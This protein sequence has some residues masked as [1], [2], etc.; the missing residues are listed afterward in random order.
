[1]SKKT[2]LQEELRQTLYTLDL[3]PSELEKAHTLLAE[4]PPTGA[5]SSATLTESH[6]E[7]D[8]SSPAVASPGSISPNEALRPASPS[9]NPKVLSPGM[10]PRMASELVSSS[11][12]R[13]KFLSL[14]RADIRFR[15]DQMN[16]LNDVE[17]TIRRRTLKGERIT[18]AS[19]V[20]ALVDTLAQLD[21]DFAEIPTEDTLRSRL[22]KKLG[23]KLSPTPAKAPP[24]A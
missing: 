11:S 3:P 6:P 12:P 21:L 10:K 2:E 23:I 16:F 22:F 17:L 9:V 1:M 20:R 14:E 7:N 5:K 15:P 4:K 18:K 19:I 13:P 24:N 8:S